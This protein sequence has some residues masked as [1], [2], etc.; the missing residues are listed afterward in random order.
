MRRWKFFLSL[1]LIIVFFSHPGF[2]AKINNIQIQVNGSQLSVRQTPVLVDGQAMN[3]EAPSYINGDTTFVHVRFVENYGAKVEWEAKTKT[4]IISHAGKEVKM[5]IDNNSIFVNGIK[6]AVDTKF[7][8]RLVMFPGMSKYAYTMIPF[9]LVAETL[10]YEVGYD[11]TK[12]T[13]YINTPKEEEAEVPEKPEEPEEPEE[14]EVPEEEEDLS[15]L[16]QVQGIRREWM[17]GREVL[18]VENSEKVSFKTMELKNP[19]RLVI[20]IKDSLLVEGLPSTY[21]YQMGFIDRVRIGQFHPDNNYKPDDKIV[22]IVLDVKPGI[23]KPKVEIKNEGKQLIIIPEDNI[24]TILSYYMEGAERFLSIK[25]KTETNYIVQYDQDL[26]TMTV[27][28][29]LD[30][31]DLVEGTVELNDGLIRD[32]SIK[33]GDEDAYILIN[34]LRDIEYDILS[35]RFD[36]EIKLSFKRDNINPFDRLIVI[37]PGHGGKD[38][39]TVQGGVREKDINLAISR[40]LNSY[41][42]EMGYTTVMTREGDTYPENKDRAKFANQLGADLYVSIHANSIANPDISGVQVLYYPNDK[43]NVKKEETV[44][45]A[46]I[47]LEEILKGTGAENK[48]IIPRDKIIVTRDTDMPAVLIETGFLTNPREREL[49]QTEEYQ[50]LMVKSITRGIERYFEIY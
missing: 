20:D 14:P 48:N 19:S 35:R 6:K 33:A 37:D 7:A 23:D 16:N 36:E 22:R 49:L 15:H 31:I 4:A 12:R 8:P 47:I 43:K 30:K 26:K 3:S 24:W 42:Q 44:A 50:D 27:N 29:P 40:K 38:P 17:D 34:F 45:L 21:D 41:L 1:L 32:I 25:A 28:L 39:G 5:S 46:K 10:G 18:V 11:E 9:R 13:P 2:A